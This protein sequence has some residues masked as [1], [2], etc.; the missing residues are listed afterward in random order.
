MALW[1][2]QVVF[3]VGQPGEQGVSFSGLR[4]AFRVTHTRAADPSPATISIWNLRPETI[5]EFQRENAVVRLLA[6]YDVPRLIFEGNALVDGVTVDRRGVDRILTVKAQDGLIAVQSSQVDVSFD[7]ETTLT[8]ILEEAL[9]QLGLPRGPSAEVP[10]IRFSD[11]TYHGDASGLMDR[12]AD[13]ASVDWLIR[14]GAIVLIG[15]GA[16]SGETASV[17]SAKNGNLIGSPTRKDTG[18]EVTA[19][20]DASMRPGMPFVVESEEI[21]GEFIADEVVFSG[22][23]GFATPF[24]TIITGVDRQAPTVSTA[25]DPDN[26]PRTFRKTLE[27]GGF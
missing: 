6:G 14:D 19:L 11:Y 23:S 12:I 26:T 21:N 16:T 20:L 13:M 8:E 2:R 7:G 1:K 22:D 27:A 5:A 18:V 17:Y 15:E 24:Y 10:D 25:P 4:V 9:G 3:E